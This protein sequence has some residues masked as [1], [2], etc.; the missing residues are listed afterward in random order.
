MPW[1]NIGVVV[2]SMRIIPPLDRGTPRIEI[3]ATGQSAE[4]RATLPLS[5]Q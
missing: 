3:A 5:S 2:L 4:V 1:E